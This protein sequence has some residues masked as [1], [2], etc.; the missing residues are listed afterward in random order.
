MGQDPILLI[1]RTVG[2]LYAF[3]VVLRFLL[4]LAKADY[5]NP[6]S[7]AVARLTNPV[8]RPLQQIVPR[9]GRIDT[10]PLLLAY[11]V[12]LATL[13]ALITVAGHSIGI[14]SLLIYALVGL[15]NTIL[16][17]YFWAVI[18]AVIISWVAPNS[19]HPAPQL[20]LQLTEPLFALA[21][22]V[23]PPIGGLDLSPILIFL[24]IQIVQSQLGR[25][26]M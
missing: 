22:K 3:I 11:V 24:V 7:Q 17:I 16:T 20:L 18:G 8:L 21:R 10:S 2:E 19:Y 12:K 9:A 26:V 23:I 14:T 4:Q 25:L 15:L 6:I 13:F 1:I 5:Y